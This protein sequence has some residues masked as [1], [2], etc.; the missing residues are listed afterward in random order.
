MV[1]DREIILTLKELDAMLADPRLSAAQEAELL[2]MRIE[3]EGLT[4]DD[5]DPRLL[6]P[7]WGAMS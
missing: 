3:L 7:A 4:D 1:D 5:T 6:A 2:E